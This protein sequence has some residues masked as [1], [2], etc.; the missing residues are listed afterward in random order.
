MRGDT[1]IKKGLGDGCLGCAFR[2]HELGVLKLGYFLAKSRALLD[3]IQRDPQGTFDACHRI[4]PN[5]QAL[6]GQLLHHLRKALPLFGSEQGRCRHPH[7]LEE[8]LGCVV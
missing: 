4:D 6:L 3:V 8:K 7:L 1:G 2:Q 5:Q